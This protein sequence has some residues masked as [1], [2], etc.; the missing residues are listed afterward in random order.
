MNYESTKINKEYHDFLIDK[1]R[2]DSKEF[3]PKLN[4][5]YY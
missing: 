2:V 5:V 4:D 3:D 1:Y